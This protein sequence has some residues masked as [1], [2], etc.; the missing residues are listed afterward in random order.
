MR[1]S[2]FFSWL[3]KRC[4]SRA[5]ALADAFIL[6]DQDFTVDPQKMKAHTGL[7]KGDRVLFINGKRLVLRSK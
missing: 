1:I 2:Q 5:S 4:R 3:A 7:R 6:P